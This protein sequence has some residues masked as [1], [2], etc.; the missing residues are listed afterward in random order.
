MRSAIPTALEGYDRLPA[1]Y[2]AVIASMAELRL[3]QVE[4]YRLNLLRLG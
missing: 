2:R 3:P 4:D 1:E